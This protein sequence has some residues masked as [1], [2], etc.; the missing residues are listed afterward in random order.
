MH[1]T[2]R[3]KKTEATRLQKEINKKTDHM[4]QKPTLKSDT[5]IRNIRYVHTDTARNLKASK[6]KSKKPKN[7][8]RYSFR[9]APNLRFKAELPFAPPT[10]TSCWAGPVDVSSL[11]IFLFLFLFLFSFFIS[12]FLF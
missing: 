7:R 4:Q 3:K 8:N 2:V 1:I 6:K 10:G 11:V 12:V 5:D 9:G